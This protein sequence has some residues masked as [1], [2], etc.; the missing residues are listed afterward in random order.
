MHSPY[1]GSS[2]HIAG[3]SLLIRSSES[4][5]A[6]QPPL[7]DGGYAWI[8]LFCAFLLQIISGGILLGVGVFIVEF[9]AIYDAEPATV[10]W[11]GSI[12][13][14]FTF[15]AGESV[16]IQTVNHLTLP[17]LSSNGPFLA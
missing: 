6:S 5:A 14:G 4:V 2:C 7:P 15:L 1:F 12:N 16:I 10:A 8:I 11:I 9:I 17:A 13:A 3:S